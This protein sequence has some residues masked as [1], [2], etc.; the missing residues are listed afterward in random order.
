MLSASTLSCD[1]PVFFSEVLEDPEEETLACRRQQEPLKLR[2]HFPPRVVR[3]SAPGLD[4]VSGETEHVV[5][6]GPELL[7][8]LIAMSESGRP[9]T[10][11]WR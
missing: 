9:R 5:L 2:H 6:I 4:T 3:R 10:P 11:T 8:I 1:R 7:G